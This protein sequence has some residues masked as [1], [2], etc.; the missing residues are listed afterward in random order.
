MTLISSLPNPISY[1]QVSFAGLSDITRGGSLIPIFL[2]EVGFGTEPYWFEVD[3]QEKLRGY[4]EVRT[5]RAGTPCAADITT[6]EASYKS[7]FSN[8]TDIT[9]MKAS[10]KSNVSNANSDV[11]SKIDNWNRGS[12]RSLQESVEL[13]SL[14]SQ[15]RRDNPVT[16]D[17]WSSANDYSQS[18]S[19]RRVCCKQK[20][21]VVL[22]MLILIIVGA[23][24]GGIAYNELKSEGQKYWVSRGRV[25][26]LVND[27]FLPAMAT[28]LPPN[29]RNS[30]RNCVTVEGSIIANFTLDL[31]TT[32][33]TSKASGEWLRSHLQQ[34]GVQEGQS[35]KWLNLRILKSSIVVTPLIS[36]EVD[37][38]TSDPDNETD[39][40]GQAAYLH[41]PYTYPLYCD[42]YK[43]CNGTVIEYLKCPQ[44]QEF[45]YNPA[46]TNSSVCGLRSNS[47]YCGG[48]MIKDI[49][50]TTE[51]RM[52]GTVTV[53]RTA[54]ATTMDV[55]TTEAMNVS[56]TTATGATDVSTQN[57]T[58]AAMITNTVR[59]GITDPSMQ[60]ATTAAVIVTTAAEVVNRTAVTGTTD[61]S[62]QNATTAATM[63]NSSTVT[64]TADT[65]TQ[66]VTTAAVIVNG[67]T[68]T[69]TIAVTSQSVTATEIKENVPTVVG[70]TAATTQNV[71][72]AGMAMNS[73]TMA[74]TT[75]A[76]TQNVTTAGM[77]MNSTAMTVPA[78]VTTQ[79]VT[80]AGMEMNSTTMAGTT[81]VTTQNVTAAAMSGVAEKK[82]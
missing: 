81:A 45:S 39:G 54:N 48:Q 63:M 37:V 9:T 20:S 44:G 75:A 66:H 27:S 19:K 38:P 13:S 53:N 6:M 18:A 4:Q 22:V 2:S 55:M 47:T 40:C 74:G 1:L 65:S 82:R 34:S 36:G 26:T 64:G 62:T 11:Y 43:A 73:T 28:A 8:T 21:T 23:I 32:F 24:S 59:T 71:T 52:T 14:G 78:A 72:T 25:T 12:A 79:N 46:T 3:R 30:T 5:T 17:T 56:K 51:A 50:T 7:N 49:T 35:V 33:D 29:S 68:V 70:T 69:G 15:H 16:F 61:V 10:S 76:T 58:T 60:N 41:L 80:T 31:R 67:T 77:A 57:A 42:E